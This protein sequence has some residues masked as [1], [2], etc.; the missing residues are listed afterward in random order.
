MKVVI[1]G[2]HLSPALALIEKL[3]KNVEVIFIGR[4]NTFEGDSSRSLEYLTITNRG[5]KFYPLAAG[6]LQRRFTKNTFVALLKV[7]LGFFAARKILK[8]EDPDVVVGFGGYLSIAVCTA[9]KSLSIPIVIHEQTLE[10]GLANKIISK[11]ANKVCISFESSKDFFPNS[12][13]ILTGNPIR[14]EIQIQ[15][16]I[17]RSDIKIE[18]KLPIIYITGGSTGSHAINDAV[19]SCIEDLLEKASVIH[20]TGDAQEFKDYERL[21]QKKGTLSDDKK[22]RYRLLKFIE[23]QEVG[24]V[25]QNAA[26]VVGR[27]GIN[28]VSELLALKKPALL[29]P[30]PFAQRNEQFK[31]AQ[32]L[33]E[34]GL[35]EILEQSDLNGKMLLEKITS[36]LENLKKYTILKEFNQENDPS[37]SLLEII[38][39]VAEKKN[40][41]QEK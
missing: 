4:K 15:N 13:T 23:P 25:M 32:M 17:V 16:N 41:P 31:N 22:S 39:D 5:V 24:F 9:A 27:S 40:N 34:T 20:Q 28:T 29:I 19:E 1:I 37:T 7:P 12:K 18:G 2:G 21:E 33:K 14:N 36:M 6:R 8:K 11:F 30:L 38:K 10:A 26:L 3:P 35:A